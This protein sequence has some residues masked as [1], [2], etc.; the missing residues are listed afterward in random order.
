MLD[1]VAVAATGPRGG[2]LSA[3][4]YRLSEPWP[5]QAR[6]GA[7]S[8][9]PTAPPAAAGRCLADT[10]WMPVPLNPLSEL[11]LLCFQRTGAVKTFADLT[12]M[13]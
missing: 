6:G 1:G 5:L 13:L 7:A 2:R 3:T 9:A 4:G 8:G 11:Y 10:G 12:A